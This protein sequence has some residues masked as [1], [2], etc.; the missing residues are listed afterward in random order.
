MPR[1]ALALYTTVYP[2][3]ER[4]VTEWYKSV[5]EQTDR[6]FEL[7]IGLDELER[8]SVQQLLGVDV[9]ANWIEGAPGDSPAQVREKALAMI[10]NV[11]SE[12]VL[13]DSDDLLHP[14]RVAAARLA[15]QTSD[16]AG[17]A[18]RLVGQQGEDLESIFTLPSHRR[19]DDVLPR[20]NVFGFSN[21][22]YRVELLKRILPIPA[23]AVLVDW[24]MSTRAWLLDT[25]LSFDCEPRMDYR[26]HPQ[27]MA[28]VRLPFSSDQ[29]I[30]ATALVSGHFKLVLADP[31]KEF[32]HSRFLELERV[33][34]EVEEFSQRVIPEPRLLAAYV[35]KFNAMAAPQIWWSCVAHPALRD[36]WRE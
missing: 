8:E 20:N 9:K 29:V 32:I 13:V 4:Y 21:S 18:L 19:P 34:R 2:G 31:P 23:D 36:L 24:F 15:L 10:V 28:L 16:L 27:N 25:K 30:R 22:A 1:T 26:Q 5:C 6:D 17:C 3:V 35:K 12:V 33:A 11:A 14:T 7:W